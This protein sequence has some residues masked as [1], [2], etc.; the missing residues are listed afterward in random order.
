MINQY[1]T[2]TAPKTVML[3]KH[4]KIVNVPEHYTYIDENGKEQKYSGIISKISNGFIGKTFETS[5]VILKF[6]PA[7]NTVIGIPEHFTYVDA[8]GKEHKYEGTAVFDETR[9]CYV[10]NLVETTIINEPIDLFKE[11]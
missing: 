5:T 11:I 10:G 6:H 9:N 7:V 4:E 8:H 1:S 3:T 2:K